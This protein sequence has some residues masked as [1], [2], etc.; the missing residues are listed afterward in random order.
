MSGVWQ[1]LENL[2]ASPSSILHYLFC[3]Q[4]PLCFSIFLLSFFTI[5]HKSW[6]VMWEVKTPLTALPSTFRVIYLSLIE[7]CYKDLCVGTTAVQH[8]TRRHGPLPIN[9]FTEV[10][11]NPRQGRNVGN[12]YTMVIHSSLLISQRSLVNGWLVGCRKDTGRACQHVW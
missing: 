4:S 7:A 6:T 2:P 8:N 5:G 12:V 10:R 3:S 9:N 11:A 1:A